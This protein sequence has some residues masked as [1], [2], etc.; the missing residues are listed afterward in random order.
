MPDEH[1]DRRAHARIDGLETTLREHF[2]EHRRFEKALEENTKMTRTIA[3]NT[4]E[5]VALVK[6]AKA[7]RK[8]LVWVTPIVA[9]V[10]AAWAWLSGSPR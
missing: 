2:K 5:L 8:F 9:A 6:G 10:M 3:D 4:S 1:F 7:G